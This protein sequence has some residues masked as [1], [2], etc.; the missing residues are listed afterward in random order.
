M[1]ITCGAR[2]LTVT[3]VRQCLTPRQDLGCWTHGL[4]AT[5]L[6]TD[7][8]ALSSSWRTYHSGLGAG[9]PAQQAALASSRCLLEC[10]TSRLVR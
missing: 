3:K 8:A 1:G 9:W 5:A 7:H 4:S 2:G 6:P 10:F